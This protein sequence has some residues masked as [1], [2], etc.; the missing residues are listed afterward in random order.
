MGVTWHWNRF[1]RFRPIV[2]HTDTHTNTHMYIYTYI[3]TCVFTSACKSLIFGEPFLV[4]NEDSKDSE[5]ST[6]A[7]THTGTCT[8]CP[9]HYIQQCQLDLVTGSELYT[10][11]TLALSLALGLSLSPLSITICQIKIKH[12]FH[13]F[14]PVA[15]VNLAR[16]PTSTRNTHTHTQPGIAWARTNTWCPLPAAESLLQAKRLDHNLN[17]CQIA[18]HGTHTHRE[19]ESERDREQEEHASSSYSQSKQPQ[20]QQ[21]RL[22]VNSRLFIN[23]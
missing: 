8:P 6:W 21:Q 3:H 17:L 18:S 9:C 5:G 7:G 19:I 23:V 13:R 14:F 4:K 1:W 11:P 15:I 16:S 2:A 10:S 22:Q 20:Q 12:I